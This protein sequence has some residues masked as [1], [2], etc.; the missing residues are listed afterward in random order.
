MLRP[1]AIVDLAPVIRIGRALEELLGQVHGVVEIVVIHVADIDVQFALE[2]GP[3]RQPVAL[4]DVREVVV[5]APVR[6]DGVVYDAGLLV[7]EAQRVT[8]VAHR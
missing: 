1:V 8:I 7:P 4:Q 5:L 3:E 6:G 2:L